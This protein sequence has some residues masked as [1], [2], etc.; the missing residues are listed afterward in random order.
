MKTYGGGGII[1]PFS[2]SELDGG[3][4]T[5][6]RSAAL[7]PGGAL[8]LSGRYG[9]EKNPLPCPGIEPCFLKLTS[10]VKKSTHVGNEIEIFNIFNLPSYN[11]FVL[12]YRCL[13]FIVTSR[14]SI[15]LKYRVF[16]SNLQHFIRSQYRK[17]E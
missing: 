1:P 11:I 4:W 14:E 2:T 12:I 13:K 17:Y 6:L 3:E 10:V 16:H 8:S 15:W 5:A 9:A 7:P